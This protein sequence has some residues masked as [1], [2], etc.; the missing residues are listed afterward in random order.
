MLLG[1]SDQKAI[2]DRR[3]SID[4]APY[5]ARCE[6]RSR[7][8][9][10]DELHTDAARCSGTEEIEEGA[11]VDDADAFVLAGR[12]EVR[13]ARHNERGVGA[14]GVNGHDQAFRNPLT[15]A[16]AMRSSRGSGCHAASKTSR[17]SDM[18]LRYDACS[19]RPSSTPISG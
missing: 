13:I 15:S 17:R 8:R 2:T 16:A 18:V 6:T 14:T 9:A 11:G 4:I 3:A 12:Q 5:V 7:N 1:D 10:Q 19:A